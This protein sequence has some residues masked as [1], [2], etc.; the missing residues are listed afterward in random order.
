[1]IDF[2]ALKCR[3]GFH[4]TM[5]V[6]EQSGY[7]VKLSHAIRERVINASTKTK[8]KEV[9]ITA[10]HINCHLMTKTC[11]HCEVVKKIMVKIPGKQ[12]SITVS[13]ESWE[14]HPD[15]GMFFWSTYEDPFALSP[16]GRKLSKK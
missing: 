11:K 3:L 7:T 16:L 9:V 6:T 1:M 14:R 2:Q 4:G 5:D 8:I 13:M 12:S 10:Q 15:E